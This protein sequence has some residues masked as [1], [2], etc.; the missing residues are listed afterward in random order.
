M[1]SQLFCKVATAFGRRQSLIQISHHRNYIKPALA[2]KPIQSS[3]VLFK[4]CAQRKVGYL[5]HVNI[6]PSKLTKDVIVFKY[7]NP[8]YFKI[9]NIFG[10]VQF[11]VWTA[12]A[13]FNINTLRD[14]PVDET[15]ENFNEQPFYKRIN[16]GTDTYR[17][18]ISCLFVGL[19]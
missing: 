1:N 6:D 3:I 2:Y 10:V 12:L 5:T 19:G 9:M 15:V 17:Y 11:V 16:L 7:D 4:H 18:G 14:I 8:R 13:E